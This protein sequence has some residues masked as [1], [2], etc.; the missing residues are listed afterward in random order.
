MMQDNIVPASVPITLDGRD[1]VLRY[2]AHAFIEYAAQCDGDLLLD[3]RE[4][5]QGLAAFGSA[6]AGQAAPDVVSFGR[7]CAKLAN[8]LW[9]GLADVQPEITRAEVARM[10]SP[11]DF[12]T[13]LPAITRALQASM[14]EQAEKPRPTR[15]AKRRDSTSID[16]AASGPV[17]ATEAESAPASSAA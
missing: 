11:A 7:V 15:A 8:V 6:V 4:L 16:G 10:F 5:G 3:I 13:L 1:L 14:P 9:A 17:S 12:P 2:R